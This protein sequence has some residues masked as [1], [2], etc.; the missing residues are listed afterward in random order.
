MAQSMDN[1]Q[2]RKTPQNGVPGRLNAFQRTMLE[3]NSWHPYNAVHVVRMPGTPNPER[4]KR[5]IDQTLE[6]RGLTG[7]NLDV[8]RASYLYD[9]GAGD[10]QLHSLSIAE[11]EFASLAAELQRQLN[12]PFVQSAPFTPFRFF[13]AAA[14]ESFFLGLAYLH[15]VADAE[16]IV[17]LLKDIVESYSGKNLHRCRPVLGPG[18]NAFFSHPGAFARKLASLPSL[19]RDLRKSSKPHYRNTNDLSNGFTFFSL[20]PANLRRLLD[21]ASAFH[22]TVNDLLLALLMKSCSMLAP[23]RLRT[24]RRRNISLGCI[25]NSRKDQ[26]AGVQAAFGLAL[27]SF[28][29]T[30]AAPEQLPLMDLAKEIGRQ[31]LAIKRKKLYLATS[32]ELSFGRIMF[33]FFSTE[34][35]KKIYQK[36]YPLWGGLTNMNINSL[37]QQRDGAGHIDYLRAVSTGP[38]TPLVLSFTTAGKVANIGISYRPTVYSSDEIERFRRSFIEALAGLEVRG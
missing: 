24:G 20:A 15:A 26:Q 13:V 38:V 9:G 1:T 28:V 19:V 7:L 16:S 25:V 35:R 4:L 22:I 8:H 21:A 6:A 36:H 12:L 10:Y 27:G 14:E 30:H 2:A 32:L 23:A 11:S 37:W 31:T 18:S 33:S 5:S 29:V 3:W 34:D 17:L